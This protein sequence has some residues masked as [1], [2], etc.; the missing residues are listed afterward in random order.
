[1]SIGKA[2]STLYE[3][4]LYLRGEH[5]CPWDRAQDLKSMYP[6]LH[7]ET[8]ELG[9]EISKN[10][11]AGIIEEWGDVLFILMMIAT[12]A[13]ET[14]QFSIEEAIHSIEAKMI[15][16]HPHVFGS[17]DASTFGELIT[18]WEDIKKSEKS[19]QPDSLMDNLPSFY[20]AL[21]RAEHIQQK[22]AEVGFDWSDHEGVIEK[23]E[24]EAREVRDAM[25][26]GNTSEA[27]DELGDLLF[28]CVNLARFKV[29][30]P[31]LL[32]NRTIDK[33]VARFKYIE[34][35]LRREGKSLEEAT[36]VE[37]DAIWERSKTRNDNA[38]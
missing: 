11:P 26:A 8:V 16:R 21:K 3:L 4:V 17:S 1:M 2:L 19:E 28:S 30:D 23:I 36:L 37:M 14:G 32:L 12:I 33:F 13:E 31:E 29:A 38:R 10:K 5:G 15:R 6:Y 35:E 34:A 25:A 18:Q 9:D 27:C 24:E 22:A 7:N 20:S